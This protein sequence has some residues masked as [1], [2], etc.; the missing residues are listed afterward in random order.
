MTAECRN[1]IQAY[2]LYAHDVSVEGSRF[3]KAKLI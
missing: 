3:W 2:V 1:T